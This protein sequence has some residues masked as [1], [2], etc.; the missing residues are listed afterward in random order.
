MSETNKRS[1]AFDFRLVVGDENEL[2]LTVV[3]VFKPMGNDPDKRAD[4]L[5]RVCSCQ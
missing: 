2:L 4:L 1:F 5:I 3:F